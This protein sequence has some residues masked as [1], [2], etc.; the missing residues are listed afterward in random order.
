MKNRQLFYFQIFS[1]APLLIF[2]LL[3]TNHSWLVALLSI[4]LV[5]S[6][7][8]YLRD[9][10]FYKLPLASVLAGSF[11]IYAFIGI[12][13][14]DSPETFKLLNSKDS[15][16]VFHFNKTVKVDEIC[17]F[18]G[19]DKKVKFDLSYSNGNKWKKFYSYSKNFPFSYRWKCLDTDI[20]TH[21]VMLDI[22]Q[23]EMMLNE[24]RFM[25][26]KKII[27]FK[28]KSK[29]FND[30]PQAKMGKTFKEGM[31][32]DEIYHG[33]TAFEL[34][35][36]I[37]VYETSH[38]YLGKYIIAMGIKLFGMNP[39]GWRFMNVLFGAFLIFVTYYFALLLFKEKE[40]SFASAVVM[41]YSFMHFTQARIALI[42][43]F[44]ILFVFISYYFLYC[45]IIKQRLK[46]LIFSGVF[47]GLASGIKWSAVFAS[48]GFLAIALFLLVSKYPLKKQFSGYK[49]ILYGLLSYV[50]VA[51]GVYGLTFFDIYLKTGSI[52]KILEYQ[53]N[54]YNYHS[55]LVGTHPYSSP[56]WSWL[57]DMKPMNYYRNI[58]DGLF[59]SISCF[60]NPAIFWTGIVAILY[61]VYV[62]IRTRAIDAM[63]IL[64][65]FLALYLP[66]IFVSRLMFIYHFYY[67]VPFLIL[68]I[69]Y[70]LRDIMAR[71]KGLAFIYWIYLAIVALLFLMFYPILSGYSIEKT[72][73]DAYLLWID[74]WWL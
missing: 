38:P 42:D 53:I 10:T 6:I 57:I 22:K 32:F 3:Y 62:V 73:V 74:G 49:L 11:L 35:H 59:S 20:S 25:H 37:P 12:G 19:I 48:F 71:Y 2:L 46:W 64:F 63:F 72:Y 68:A 65:A 66:Y 5:C 21:E 51:V 34:I 36:D 61:L 16:S 14:Q 54:M 43:T 15:F 52:E 9:T 69:I 39:Y 30:E 24:V 44:G 8:S 7:T 33:R 40:F 55:T 28:S 26:H 17:Y 18:V 41:L 47:F 13:N 56:W 50:V 4:F 1:I 58:K 70:M 23:G 31:Y 67:A 29:V 45:F 60:G 27:P